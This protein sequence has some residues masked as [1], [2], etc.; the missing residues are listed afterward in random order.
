[1]PDLDFEMTDPDNWL[2]ELLNDTDMNSVD[3]SAS[4]FDVHFSISGD[5]LSLHMIHIIIC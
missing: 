1:M 2:T 5:T 4:A 3:M